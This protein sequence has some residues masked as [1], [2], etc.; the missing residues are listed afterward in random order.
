[1]PYFYIHFMKINV[2]VIGVLSMLNNL[3]LKG[4]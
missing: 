4:E 1:M 3:I 2:Y